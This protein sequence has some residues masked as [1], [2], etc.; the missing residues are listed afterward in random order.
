[1]IA[2]TMFVVN[3]YC[4]GQQSFLELEQVTAMYE[5]VRNTDFLSNVLSPKTAGQVKTKLKQ[6]MKEEGISKVCG[7]INNY[8]FS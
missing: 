5:S 7:G 4:R 3:K 2:I 8:Y 1:M 6:L